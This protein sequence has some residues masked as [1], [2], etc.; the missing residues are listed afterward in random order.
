MTDSPRRGMLGPGDEL[1][2]FVIEAVAGRG[3]MGVV[4]R[5]RQ[6][7][8]DRLVALKIIADEYAGD[9]AFRARFQRESSIAAQIEHPNVIPVH[10][11]GEAD[12]VLYIVMRFVEGTDMRALIAQ[13]GRLEPRRAAAIADAVGQ[14]L[15]AAHGH[16]LVHRDVKPANILIATAGGR[17]HVYLSDFGLSRHIEGSQGLTGTGA[18]LGTI[19]YVAPEQARGDHVDARTDVYSLGCVLFQALTGSVPFPLDNDLAKLYAHDRRPPPSALERVG[20]LPAAFEAVL[21]RAMAKAPDDRYLSAGDLGRAAVA[22]ASGTTLSRAERNVAVGGAAPAETGPVQAAPP[23]G[24]E[25]APPAT[26]ATRDEE[27]APPAA[28]A[29]PRDEEPAPPAAAAT[30]DED[31]AP[32]A[33]AATRDDEPAPP[34]AT[35]ATRRAP[36]APAGDDRA[37]PTEVEPSGRRPAPGRRGLL[38]AAGSVVVAV[39]AVVLLL[40]SGGNDA[41]TGSHGAGA[42]AGASAGAG[43]GAGAGTAITAG[44]LTTNPS[45]ESDTSGWDSS[46]ADLAPEQA[47]DAPDGANVV[48]VSWTGSEGSYSIDDNPDTVASAVKG[49]AYGASA[50]VKAG[51]ATDGKEVCIALRERTGDGAPVGYDA[52]GVTAVAGEYRQVRVS[53]VAKA[54]GS[55]IDVYVF[56]QSSGLRSGES[57]LVDAITLTAGSG[58]QGFDDCSA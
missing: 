19:D 13:A 50:W 33:A 27:P 23:R 14:A 9:P 35:A 42:N 39:I 4:Y 5:A 41:R 52:G 25:P 6:R 44:N 45:F 22:A 53:H 21:M 54:D 26:A 7:R 38:V 8:P 49:R 11:V 32:P 47:K 28:A 40:T 24:E 15:D 58:A 36:R 17:E 56:R 1:A 46:N 29:P 3:G 57:F 34:P 16:G 51:D 43:A 20:D 48:R 31:A 18:F 10:A 30:P 2:G 55:T 12:G 37:A